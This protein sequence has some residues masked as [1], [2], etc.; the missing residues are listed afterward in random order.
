MDEGT[1]A[2]AKEKM[3]ETFQA[4]FVKKGDAEYVFDKRVEFSPASDES[5]DWDE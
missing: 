2:L 4:N 1:L 5:N 3:E